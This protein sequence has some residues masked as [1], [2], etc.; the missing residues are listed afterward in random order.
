M[1][2]DNKIKALRYLI[3]SIQLGK[4]VIHET[5]QNFDYVDV[6]TSCWDHPQEHIL[7]GSTIV[8]ELSAPIPKKNRKKVKVVTED[9]L[10]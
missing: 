1:K 8:L 9:M 5:R 6:S 10:K 7:N 2:L 3:K 4:I